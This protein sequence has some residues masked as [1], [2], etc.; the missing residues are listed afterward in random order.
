MVRKLVL[1]FSINPLTLAVARELLF[2]PDFMADARRRVQHIISERDSMCQSLQ[3]DF[4]KDVLKVFRSEGNF[5]LI[6]IFDDAQFARLLENL[7]KSGVK[8]LNTSNFPLL[9]NTFRVSIGNPHENDAFYQCLYQ[10][11]NRFRIQDAATTVYNVEIFPPISATSPVHPSSCGWPLA[12]EI[13][14]RHN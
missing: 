12:A 4:G 6:R 13:Q 9:H 10:S 8:V 3:M 2:Q 14:K 5:L 1:N 7:E 11:L